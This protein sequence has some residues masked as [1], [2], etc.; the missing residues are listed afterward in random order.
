M[1]INFK[2]YS[3]DITKAYERMN[4]NLS[5]KPVEIDNILVPR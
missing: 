2:P 4:K 5:I 1:N 3:Y